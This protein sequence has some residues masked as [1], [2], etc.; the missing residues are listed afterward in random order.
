[1]AGTLAVAR[2]AADTEAADM[3]AFM[4]LVQCPRREDWLYKLQLAG[5]VYAPNSSR[6]G[7]TPECYW[8]EGQYLAVQYNAARRWYMAGQR[9]FDMIVDDTKGVGGM[10][11]DTEFLRRMGYPDAWHGLMRSS[12]NAPALTPGSP[13]DDGDPST[14]W[15]ID[16]AV[17]RSG[18]KLLEV[19]AVPVSGPES[20]P[21]QENWYHDMVRNGLWPTQPEQWNDLTDDLTRSFRYAVRR[22]AQFMG[23][24]T[25]VVY[26]VHTGGDPTGEDMMNAAYYESACERAGFA[27]RRITLEEVGYREDVGF[28]HDHGDGTG[29]PIKIAYFLWP[30]DRLLSS[31]FGQQLARHY[32]KFDST[33]ILVL[34]P[35]WELAVSNQA[36]NVWLWDQYGDDPECRK[37]LLPSYFKEDKPV[38]MRSY[39]LKPTIGQEGAGKQVVING[40]PVFTSSEPREDDGPSIVQEFVELPTVLDHEGRGKL[41][42]VVSFWL[43]GH[44]KPS[45]MSIRAHRDLVTTANCHT[46]PH[47]ITGAPAGDLFKN[48]GE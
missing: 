35:P 40:S 5:L 26:F 16:C 34:G 9:I 14:V 6:P 18:L 39:V 19:N 7:I 31:D 23:L 1:V 45:A 20:G 37:L 28:Y 3:A 42:V 21:G 33:G 43:T 48:E 8:G 13:D 30:W 17:K 47:V 2:P 44:R 10:L 11:R 41:N 36:L 38:S 15:R 4:E 24:R 29:D 22:A 27:T 46:F 32:G 12:W 25:P